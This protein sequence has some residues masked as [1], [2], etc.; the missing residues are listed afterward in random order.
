MATDSQ[1]NI[2]V[3]DEGNGAIK[4]FDA[5]GNFILQ[6][7]E[8]ILGHV[9][10]LSIDSQDYIH[11]ADPDNNRITVFDSHGKES[12]QS[13]TAEQSKNLNEPCG[14]FCLKESGTIIGD[15]SECLLKHYDAKGNLIN[16]VKK[17]GLD[18]D[19]IYFLA[20]D[21]QYGI[22]ASDFW[23]SQII[24]LNSNLDVVDIYRKQG[25]RTGEIGKTAGLSIHNGRLAAA[26][27]DGR[28]V[29][30]FNLSG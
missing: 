7:Q 12:L 20:C 4:K 6:F 18:F 3:I 14:V 22:F 10:S 2:Y 13:F 30:V 5:M 29:Q 24:H 28:R 8:G 27:F 19:D 9:F 17:E 26:N 11:V 21:P 23:H 1:N 16:K 15:R 25:N